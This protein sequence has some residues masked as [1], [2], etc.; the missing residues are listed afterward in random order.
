[1]NN[2]ENRIC[3]NVNCNNTFAYAKHGGNTKKFCSSKCRKNFHDADGGR[4]TTT[5]TTTETTTTMQNVT[6]NQSNNMGVNIDDLMKMEFKYYDMSGDFWGLAFG[7]RVQDPFNVIAYGSPGG[8]K[9]TMSLMFAD[10]FGRKFGKVKYLS[11]EMG[12]SN[13]LK[14]MV[15][16][17]GMT[18][19][20]VF[21][22][23]SKKPLNEL[24][25]ELKKG[26][27]KM[28]IIDSANFVGYSAEDIE[29][30]KNSVQGL[31]TFII[32]QSTKDGKFRGANDYAHNADVI[33]KVVDLEVFTE[34]TRFAAK[35]VAGMPII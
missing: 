32:L 1:M 16:R 31:S 19:K 20:K 5:P 25:N 27:F 14:D 11:A 13:S 21:F 3:K 23:K 18:S 4:M 7:E 8:G 24:I 30:I 17:L 6:I 12:L 28:L 35:N 10:Y 34:K 2:N 9:T 33:L 26:H 29:M 15:K 22:D